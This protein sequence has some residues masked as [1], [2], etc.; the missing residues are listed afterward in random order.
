MPAGLT[1]PK[2]LY[3]RVPEHRNKMARGDFARS[4]SVL[5]QLLTRAGGAIIISERSPAKRAGQ[6][7][8]RMR[9]H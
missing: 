3:Y 8:F 9:L 2:A 7:G 4:S 6:G 1:R 5:Q